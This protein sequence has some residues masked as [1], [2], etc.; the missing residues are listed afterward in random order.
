MSLPCCCG[1]HRMATED[2]IGRGVVQNIECL[3]FTPKEQRGARKL[4]CCYEMAKELSVDTVLDG[5]PAENILV[6]DTVHVT[7]IK[8]S[9]VWIDKVIGDD[10]VVPHVDPVW[11]RIVT[12]FEVSIHT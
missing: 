8:F 1:R 5:R 3:L 7:W 9:G 2:V 6:S 10:E 11:R 4:D 12:C